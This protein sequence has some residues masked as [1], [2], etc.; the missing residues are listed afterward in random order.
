MFPLTLWRMWRAYSL[1]DPP[2]NTAMEQAISRNDSTE[3]SNIKHNGQN[4]ELV[5]T[6]QSKSNAVN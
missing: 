2:P 3:I 5:F 1:L 4:N 6:K